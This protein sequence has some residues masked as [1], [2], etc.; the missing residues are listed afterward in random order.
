MAIAFVHAARPHCL[1][2]VPLA[3]LSPAGGRLWAIAARQLDPDRFNGVWQHRVWP[4]KRDP[5][6][7]QREHYCQH[8]LLQPCP[9]GFAAN[10][11]DA[12][13]SRGRADGA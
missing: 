3:G 2:I 13:S 4:G 1:M 11:V 7:Q 9:V 10:A 12:R 8:Q 5:H 6:L